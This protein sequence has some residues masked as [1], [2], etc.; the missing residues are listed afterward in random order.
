M[1]N[2]TEEINKLYD[3]IKNAMGYEP[4]EE[5]KNNVNN[6]KEVFDR[7]N[8]IPPTYSYVPNLIGIFSDGTTIDFSEFISIL[9]LEINFDRYVFPL[10]SL[11]LFIPYKYIP[12][13]QYDDKIK[14]KLSILYNTTMTDSPMLYDTLFEIDLSKIKQ[15]S[16]PVNIEENI[17]TEDRQ[18]LNR[19]LMEL[20]LIPTECLKANKVLFS[21]VYGDCN[22]AQIISLMTANLDN[23]TFIQQPDNI[24]IY[25]QMIFI[26]YNVFYSLQLLENFY[27]IYD[28]GLKMFYGFDLFRIQS[29]NF[30]DIQGTNKVKITFSKDSENVDSYSYIGNGFTK[31]GD[32]NLI[33]L[34]PDRVKIYDTR[35]Y[36]K[37]IFGTNV[38][39]FSRDKNAFYEQ[40]R[41]YDLDNNISIDKTKVY[42]NNYNNTNKEKEFLSHS[43]YTKKIELTLNDIILD[44]PSLFKLFKLEFESD[45]YSNMSSNFVING[46]Y[47]RLSTSNLGIGSM[48]Y[49][50][51]SIIELNEV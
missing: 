44:I 31:I 14:F 43:L 26:P 46:Y 50:N 16:S 32:D 33:T 37:E 41:E 11:Q 20:K 23:K 49:K 29:R 47:W 17:N 4:T 13:I 7:E 42:L 45:Y 19:A 30:Y 3:N 25:D 27:G 8:R 1:S 10:F 22:V 9:Q 36:D 5:E 38:T 51:D 48:Y 6:L 28:R 18:T 39:T 12:Q 24:K 15:I 34:T 40:S 35:Q 2:N 21:G